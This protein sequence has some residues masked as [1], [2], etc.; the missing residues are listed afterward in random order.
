MDGYAYGLLGY[1]VGLG[2]DWTVIII[3]TWMEWQ[4]HH[5][6]FMGEESRKPM[7]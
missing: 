5:D 4:E 1:G 2:W 3:R 6:V 7:I